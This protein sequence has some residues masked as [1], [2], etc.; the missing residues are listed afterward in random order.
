MRLP[1]PNERQIRVQNNGLKTATDFVEWAP[2]AIGVDELE[3]PAAL[4]GMIEES[5]KMAKE[6]SCRRCGGIVIDLATGR[7]YC[8]RAVPPEILENNLK[9][10][11]N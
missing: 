11:E 5:E 7:A 9:L 10:A 2:A 1:C 3:K 4:T 8:G 6:N